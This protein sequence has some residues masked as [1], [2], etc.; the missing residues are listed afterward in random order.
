MRGLTSFGSYAFGRESSRR[1]ESDSHSA[2]T[3]RCQQ[4]TRDLDRIQWGRVLVACIG[5]GSLIFVS[6]TAPSLVLVESTTF[7]FEGMKME[8]GFM[9]QP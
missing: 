3:R 5:V 9:V 2:A 6:M 7:R 4:P 1:D 8:T